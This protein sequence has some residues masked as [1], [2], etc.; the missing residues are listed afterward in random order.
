MQQQV[1]SSPRQG[2]VAPSQVSSSVCRVQVQ[3]GMWECAALTQRHGL[4]ACSLGQQQ[5]Q[6]CGPASVAET[7]GDTSISAH[8]AEPYSA[9][10]VNSI[11]YLGH[12]LVQACKDPTVVLCGA[13]LQSGRQ[14]QQALLFHQE[15]V[16][17]H[18]GLTY[19]LFW[20]ELIESP[21]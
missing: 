16:P 7:S 12:A 18:A 10:A 20:T 17:T 3:M 2:P 14:L 15:V 19:G 1:Y 8:A 5:H 11:S 21:Y 13:C 6:P 4:G 9:A